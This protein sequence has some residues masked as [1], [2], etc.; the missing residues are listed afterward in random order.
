[1]PGFTP[2]PAS[3]GSS[4]GRSGRQIV[5]GVGGEPR[6]LVPS[7]AGMPGSTTEHLFELIH[8]SLVTYDD[9]AQPVA[10]VARAL[11]SLEDGTWRVFDDG[12]METVWQLRA[13]VW[14]HDGRPF[15]ADDV[16]FSWR[17]FNDTSLPIATRRVARL[18]D[19]MDAPNEHTVVMHWRT[20]Y[21]FADQISGFDLTL[22][23]AHILQTS[24]DLRR[25]Q[26]AGHP[27][28][29]DEFVGLGPYRLQRWP[30]G[31]SIELAAFDQYFLG[32]P[33]ADEISV[34]FLPD[35]NTAMAAV[36]AGSVDMVLPRRALHG[37]IQSVRA[38]WGDDGAGVLSVLPG[39]SWAYLAP[40]FSSPQPEELQDPRIR[41]ALAHAIDRGAISEAV[42][43]DRSLASDLWVPIN[44]P[45]YRA[46]SEGAPR[47]DYSPERARDLFREAGWRRESSDDVLIRQGRRFELELTTT[48]GWERIAALVAESWRNVGVAVKET[49]L[50]LG[51]VT[52][53]QG[54]A[55][56]AGVELANGAPN[57]ALI[58]G[59]LHSTS[60]PSAENQFVGANRGR[61]A[62]AELDALFDRL[63]VSFERTERE[64]V[65]QEIANHVLRDLPIIGLLF[66][67]AMAMVRREVRNTRVPRTVAPM[68]RLSM[69]WNA[70]EWERA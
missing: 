60:M 52:D 57:L 65:E 63:W 13:D 25:D 51:A 46:L 12:T 20:R 35:D 55:A 50:S 21:A 17:V 34:R 4:T 39:Y 28:W 70:H 42:V 48:A 32:R 69:T 33:R 26:I 3:T 10:R 22:L 36:L 14:W 11:P 30:P 44:D 23:P 15:T 5:V 6:T 64:A 47:Y 8:Q 62:S 1:V 58:D 29:R 54:R 67:P 41:I 16:V 59:R 9:Q 2:G 53:R 31:S 56:Y 66:Y 37:V 18:I 68:G 49:V 19:G 38:R 45:R 43:G 61:Y 40:Q 27:Y 7:V 24:F